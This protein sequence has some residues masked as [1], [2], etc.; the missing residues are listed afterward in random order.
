M[1]KV[2]IPEPCHENWADFTPTEKGAFCGSCATDVIDFSN[3][4]PF[5]VKSILADNAG[6]HLCGRFKKSQLEELNHDY[7]EWNGQSSTTFRSKFLYACLIVFGMTLFTGCSIQESSIVQQIFSNNAALNLTSMQIGNDP[8]D[9]DSLKIEKLHLKGKVAYTPIVKEEVIECTIISDTNEL[10]EYYEVGSVYYQ[11]QELR[12]DDLIYDPNEL[13]FGDTIITT[14]AEAELLRGNITSIDTAKQE[15]KTAPLFDDSIRE[16][17]ID[18]NTKATADT[19][20]NEVIPEAL[21]DD[22]MIDGLIKM[23]PEVISSQM[24]RGR[25]KVEP[26]ELEVTEIIEIDTIKQA[27]ESKAILA[28]IYIPEFHATVFPNPTSSQTVIEIQVSEKALYNV[29]LYAIDGKKIKTLFNGLY[30]QGLQRISL[31]LST[32]EA[33]S[34]LIVINGGKQKESFKLEKVE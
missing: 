3:K 33:G 19:T 11:P 6:A 26:K 1:K 5:E 14:K 29:Y 27:L 4:T 21:Y 23:E 8:V 16:G 10:E 28:P 25:I 18:L 13:I 15:A 9:P 17:S 24:I 34:Y 22:Q 12:K 32:Y 2:S 20:N 7:V 31:N 30:Q